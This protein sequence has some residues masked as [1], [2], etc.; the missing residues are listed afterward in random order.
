MKNSCDSFIEEV[1]SAVLDTRRH[2]DIK[3]ELTDHIQLSLE[4]EMQKN[5]TEEDAI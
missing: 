5:L 4:E 2:Q 1:L 3:D